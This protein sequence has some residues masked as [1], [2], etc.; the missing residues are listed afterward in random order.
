MSV[1]VSPKHNR[2]AKAL[3]NCIIINC[4]YYY[5]YYLTSFFYCLVSVFDRSL[6][7][8]SCRVLNLKV[9]NIRKTLLVETFHLRY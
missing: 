8:E 9:L 2:L 5:Y 6:R 7:S 1:D 3:R 4:Y